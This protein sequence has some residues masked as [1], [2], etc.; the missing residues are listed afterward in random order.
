MSLIFKPLCL[1]YG[2]NV[3]CFL[4]SNFL[5]LLNIFFIF[6]SSSVFLLLFFQNIQKGFEISFVLAKSTLVSEKGKLTF[7]I[8]AVVAL[9]S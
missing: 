6:G 1:G 9:H 5:L 7:S 2:F 3:N 8:A 4:L